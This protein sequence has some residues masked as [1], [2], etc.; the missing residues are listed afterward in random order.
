MSQKDQT[1][2]IY[3]QAGELVDIIDFYQSAYF[4]R[5]FAGVGGFQIIANY[6][7]PSVP[8]FTV[9]Q[10][11]QF[12]S[13]VRRIGIITKV[14]DSIGPEGK[15]SMQRTVTGK[16][17][18]NVLRRRIILPTT[19]ANYTQT[20]PSESV[21]LQTL[22]DQVGTGAPTP[23]QMSGITIPAG[24]GGGPTYS[25]SARF[26]N[27]E[28]EIGA[29]CL[30][31]GMGYWI[32]RTPGG[33][34]PW[35]IA[36]G[37]GLDRSES[38]TTNPRAVFSTNFDTLKEGSI[39][40]NIENYRNYTYAGG[41]GSGVAREIY[42]GY[43]EASEPTGIDRIEQFVDARDLFDATDIANRITAKLNENSYTLYASGQP[44]Q[45]S[46]LTLGTDYDL[47]DTV[48]IKVGTVSTDKQI[49]AI[50][51]NWNGNGENDYTFDLTFGKPLP[52]IQNAM[53]QLQAS[54]QQILQNTELDQFLSIKLRVLSQPFGSVLKYR[55]TTDGKYRRLA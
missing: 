4:E 18:K 50:Q 6:N 5:Q 21:F 9:G 12:G 32:E 23:R 47:G 43:I 53:Q 15:G 14:E 54:L 3:S 16:E 51:E 40:S 35:A 39:E 10:F 55:V 25:L 2:Y 7:L 24:S 33:P 30:A 26:K 52:T 11:V 20:G 1:I 38:Q 22:R 46:P 29:L 27:L 37:F 13:D 28:D 45:K 48:T 44:L 31:C 36:I 49:Q 19:Q 41:Q 8:S 34:T 42:T 17:A